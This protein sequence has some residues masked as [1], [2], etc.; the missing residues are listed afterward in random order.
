MKVLDKYI[1]FADLFSL[2]LAS[3]LIEHTGIND[4]T[5]KLVDDQQ[6]PFKPIYSLGLVESE[7]LKAYIKTNLAN[8]FIKLSKLPTNAPILFDQK[9]NQSLGLCV[10]YRG[11]N[12]LTIKNRY[13]LSLV[14]KSMNRLKRARWFTQ[15]K[16]TSAYHQMKICKGDK[17][18]TVF[19]TQ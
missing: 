3:K 11:L 15:L 19:K 2:D 18:K 4:H 16:L 14:R 10:N 13:P 7:T 8:R 5:I 6:P 17:W 1:N 12:N 9:L